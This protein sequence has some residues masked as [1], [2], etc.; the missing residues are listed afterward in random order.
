LVLVRKRLPISTD[1]AKYPMKSAYLADFCL[2][3]S[4][5]ICQHWRL[6]YGHSYG[7]GK[8]ADNMV[9][10]LSAVKVSSAKAPGYYGDGGNLYFRVAPGGTRGWIFRFAMHGRT[11]DMGLGPYPDVSL[12]KA[13]DLAAG[14][15]E[16]VRAGVDPIED[17]K[18]RRAASHLA[19]VRAMTFDECCRGYIAAHEGSWTSATHRQQWTNT[20]RDY[21]APVLGKLPVQTIDTGLVMKVLQPIWNTKTETASRVRGRIEVVL[22]WATVSNFRQGENPARWRG[23]LEHLLARKS[24]IRTIAHHAALPYAE[25]GAFM[26]ALRGDSSVAARA[27]EFLILT[28]SR[29]GEVLGATWAEINLADS[30]WTI[31]AGRMKA[32]K[33]HRVP[34]SAPVVASLRVMH[35]IRRGDSV[36][37][38]AREGKSL[39]EVSVGRLIQRMGYSQTIHG[40]RST[41]RDWAAE[42]TNFPR[43]VAEMAL[44]HAIPSAVEAA[45]RRG[46]LLEKRR[47]LM[48]AWAQ[49]CS[50]TTP[51]N[52]VVPISSVMK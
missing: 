3:V 9:S 6:P 10:R 4:A 34:L 22:D 30:V 1:V 26:V 2:Y 25:V 21:I 5:I 40:F 35:R 48:D 39:S 37:P 43:A 46:D 31:P 14:C 45:Y 8:K 33:E 18:A 19:S 27:L 17:R 24:K 7:Q 28:A 13:R 11:R 38:G 32:K 44:A 52:T 16:Q 15:R 12:A 50:T 42:R 41:F 29:L 51:D 47:R 49:F 20:V 23:H 36:F